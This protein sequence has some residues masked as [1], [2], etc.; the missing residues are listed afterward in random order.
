MCFLIVVLIFTEF[1]TKIV[2]PGRHKQ[3]GVQWYDILKLS[4]FHLGKYK[5]GKEMLQPS[6]D[7]ILHI[8]FL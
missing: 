5:A 2:D 6:I 7:M 3:H 8:L 4:T 1:M